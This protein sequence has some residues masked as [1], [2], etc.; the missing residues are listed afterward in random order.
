MSVTR[1]S[2]RIQ[3]ITAFV[4]GLAAGAVLL[5]AAHELNRELKAAVIANRMTALGVPVP[6]QAVRCV[7]GRVALRVSWSELVAGLDRTALR[8]LAAASTRK[9]RASVPPPTPR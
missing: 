5:W 9:C 4:V 2:D 3:R 6:P 7:A 1:W 8:G